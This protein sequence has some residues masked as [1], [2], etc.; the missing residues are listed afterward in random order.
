[1]KYTHL[2]V[3]ESK[4]THIDMLIFGIQLFSAMTIA[5]VKIIHLHNN[6]LV[7]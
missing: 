7:V 5:Q 1:M 4:K 3:L 2:Q 6:C